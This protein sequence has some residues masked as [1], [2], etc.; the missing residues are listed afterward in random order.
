MSRISRHTSEAVGH[1][2]WPHQHLAGGEKWL[3]TVVNGCRRSLLVARGREPV[4][5][6]RTAF[7]RS[8]DLLVKEPRLEQIGGLPANHITA[9]AGSRPKNRRNVGMPLEAAKGY[10]S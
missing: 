1:N 4:T 7:S 6:R 3:Q 2:T 5:T 10:I 8:R 9:A